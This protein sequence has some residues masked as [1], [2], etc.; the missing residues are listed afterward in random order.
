[1]LRRKA[2]RLLR[3]GIGEKL[4]PIQC[5]VQIESVM[6]RRKALRLSSDRS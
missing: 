6:K 1:M 4:S 5:K 2:L 3:N